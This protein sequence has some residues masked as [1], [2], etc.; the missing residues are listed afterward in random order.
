MYTFDL[1]G[2]TADLDLI[3]MTQNTAGTCD[4]T[5][6]C[7]A[8]S[9]TAGTANESVTFMADSTKTYYIGVDG[10]NNATSFYTLKMSSTQCTTTPPSCS[11]GNVP[12]N[13][14]APGH[15]VSG[16][17][18]ATG[19]TN[20]VTTWCNGFGTS[21]ESGKEF[22]HLFQ[23]TT[24]GM[25][26]LTLSGLSADLDLIVFET[27]GPTS[28]DSGTGCLGSSANGGTTNETVTF[29]AY[30]GRSYW[31]VVEGYNGGMS[32]YTLT[33]TAGCP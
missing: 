4:P 27:T 20:N 3:V 8:F 10:K 12:I 33:L 18:T 2:L 6:A 25:Y 5:L 23:P 14:A 17:N 24:T 30:Q 16:N 32:N 13:C 31:A 7:T 26:T 29:Q 21:N 9:V 11:N 22:A 15:A 1:T 19:S 28:C